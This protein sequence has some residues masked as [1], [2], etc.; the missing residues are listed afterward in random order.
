VTRD[1]TSTGDVYE[2]STI[3]VEFWGDMVQGNGKRGAP[4]HVADFRALSY[5]MANMNRMFS[6]MIL[7]PV[8]I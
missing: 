3:G 1:W 6:K 8:F 2:R 5:L 7:I 4:R